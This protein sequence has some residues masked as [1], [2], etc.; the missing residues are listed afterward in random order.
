MA[1]ESAL[2]KVPAMPGLMAFHAH[3]DDEVISTG[4]V[5]SQYA[6]RGEQV[7][8]VTA[9]DGAEGE[10]HNYDDPDSI[11]PRL[12]EV[13]AE[14]VRAALDILGVEHHEF[15]GYRDS[16]M[17]GTDANG[18]PDCFWQADFMEATKRLVAL[19]RRF[20]P[21]VLVIY[22]PYGGYGHPDHINVHRIGLAAYY[23]A[24]DL[25]RFPLEDG[26]ELWE[27]RKLYWT[28]WPRSR[29]VQ[30]TEMRLERGEATEEDLERA[31]TSGTKDED[32]TTW[33]DVRDRS[34]LKEKALR[35]H[36][37]QIPEDW[38]LLSIPDEV[39]PEVLGRESFVRVFSRVDAPVVED[40]LF[41]GLR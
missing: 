5:L 32:I 34:E 21:E 16:G 12:A 38:F 2:T 19:I 3:P 41:A 9:T 18:H 28:T 10:I 17:M 36:R 26:E 22:D 33:I 39:R 40:D 35:A 13:R 14:E 4:G 6:A 24:G 23:A 7:V 31:R 29:F 25:G 30:F 20:Q 27:P 1:N 11:R 8:V 15:L 37:S